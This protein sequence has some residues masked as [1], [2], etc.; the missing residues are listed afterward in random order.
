MTT[1]AKIITDSVDENNNRITTF[2]L[3]Y[4][5]FFHSEFNTHR[6]FSRNAASSRAIPVKR[7]LDSI[8]NDMSIPT[9]WGKNKA[10]M[11][12]DVELD[13]NV[14]IIVDPISII[15]DTLNNIGIKDTY[16]MDKLLSIT[17][18]FKYNKLNITPTESWEFAAN[19]ATKIA[20]QM[21]NAGLHKQI[22]NRI[23]EP[24]QHITVIVTSTEWDNFFKLRNHKD[25]QPEFKVLANLMELALYDSFP[26]KLINPSQSKT[27]IY[28][29]YH[30]PYVSEEE[31]NNLSDIS[32]VLMVSAARCAR[33]SYL[34]HDGTSPDIK[35]DIRLANILLNAGHMSPFEHQ[36]Q[37]LNISN[38]TTTDIKNLQYLK[39][40]GLTH[41]DLE[42][43]LWSS[44][45]KEFGQFRNFVK[46]I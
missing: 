25:S 24:F 10:G 11:Q 3:K 41:I 33:V 44:N 16:I 26:I 39:K 5:R 1:T 18:S 46:Y 28:K 38:D 22:V 29:N 7:M 42:G 14:R 8:S 36:A 19:L 15:I 37:I 12:A 13:D 35:K 31:F 2:E 32:L 30:I 4:Q 20:K 21:S 34:N 6:M 43:N 17:E 9:Y 40:R 45:F 27:P 23:T